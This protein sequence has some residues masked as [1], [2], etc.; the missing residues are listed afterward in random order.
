MQNSLDRFDWEEGPDEKYSVK[1]VKIL[2][3]CCVCGR[4]MDAKF[5]KNW[6]DQQACRPCIDELEGEYER[7]I[8]S[9]SSSAA[10]TN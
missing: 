5:L 2:P 10:G 4:R 3:D 7:S 8:A 6:N 9:T 1:V